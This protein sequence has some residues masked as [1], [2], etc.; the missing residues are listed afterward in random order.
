V[1]FTPHVE[2][3]NASMDVPLS[4]QTGPKWKLAPLNKSP[5]KASPLWVL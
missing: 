4:M 5:L 3:E 2:R 1:V